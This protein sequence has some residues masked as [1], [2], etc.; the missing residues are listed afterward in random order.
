M[1]E[2]S[3][4]EA[5]LI[6]RI[7]TDSDNGRTAFSIMDCPLDE[8]DLNEKKERARERI[9]SNAE[10]MKQKH[11]KVFS[12]IGKPVKL[13]YLNEIE[14]KCKSEILESD[15]YFDDIQARNTES[16]RRWIMTQRTT[17]RNIVELH[18]APEGGANNGND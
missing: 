15:R 4:R 7:R 10:D 18:K 8:K 9:R 2:L 11:I 1:I 6:H 12:S 17:G 14:S 3:D 16:M 5:Y 13:K